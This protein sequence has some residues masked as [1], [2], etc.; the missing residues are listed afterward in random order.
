[1]EKKMKTERRM[2]LRGGAT[3][4]LAVAVAAVSKVAMAALPEPVLQAKP[5]PCRRWYEQ[6]PTL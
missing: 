3:A 4:G 6:R 1:M 5:T 2:F